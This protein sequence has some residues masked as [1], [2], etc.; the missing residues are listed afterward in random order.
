MTDLN[1]DILLYLDENSELDSI[2]YAQEH[3]HDHQKVVGSI[4]S[5]SSQ[6]EG[7]RISNI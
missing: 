5:L 2:E 7:V 4:K 1:N 6:S 3:N